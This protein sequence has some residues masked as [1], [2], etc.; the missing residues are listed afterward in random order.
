V[1]VLVGGCLWATT[2]AGQAV[3]A[4]PG[5]SK[6]RTTASLKAAIRSA[7]GHLYAYDAGFVM[8]KTGVL[9][10]EVN[11]S[12]ICAGAM[13]PAGSLL[14]PALDQ[15][16][17][18]LKDGVDMFSKA[19]D[20]FGDQLTALENAWRQLKHRPHVGPGAVSW[21]T[22]ARAK[23]SSAKA[24]WLRLSI[25]FQDDYNLL[26]SHSDCSAAFPS[27]AYHLAD[28]AHTS[29]T[30]AHSDVTIALDEIK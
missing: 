14:W 9:E 20:R 27:D 6:P 22:D 28:G 16:L 4:K 3:A 1:T 17:P 30:G 10:Q 13:Q 25:E 26:K 18:G 11:D 19:V 7:N 21:M 2:T 23:Y 15:A 5:K 24:D 29:D 8:E 12:M